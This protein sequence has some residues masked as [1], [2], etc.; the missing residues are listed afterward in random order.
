MKLI[1]TLFLLFCFVFTV[2]SQDSASKI[3]IMKDDV[4]A[5][6]K[7]AGE[8]INVD[9]VKDAKT[10]VQKAKI[11][12]PNMGIEGNITIQLK[13]DKIRIE[14]QTANMN[15]VNGF[16]G[17]GAW[18]QNLAMGL[19]ILEGAEKLNL[20]SETLPYA[21]TPE[22][23]Y[24]SI[25]LEGKETF[26]D[27]ECYKIKSSKKGMDPVYEYIDAKTYLS[28]GEVRVIPSPMGKMK[29]T[30]F[31]KNYKKHEKGFLYPSLLVQSM[32]PV[33]IEVKMIS[34][35]LNEPLDDKIFNTPA[36]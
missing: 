2:H 35:K 7:K 12:I 10:M 22:K 1:S 34:I 26:N 8:A 36:Q 30:S 16:D 25:E 33:Q 4:K 28:L 14:S 18:S 27:V 24:D 9:S 23:F 21:F 31:Y 19:R 29:A 32:G 13:D 5:I 15:E 6:M 3:A 20:I 11:S 17:K